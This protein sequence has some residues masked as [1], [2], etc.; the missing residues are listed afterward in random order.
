MS[1][2]CAPQL[3]WT[4]AQEVVLLG[5]PHRHTKAAASAS[6]KH[7]KQGCH[8]AYMFDTKQIRLAGKLGA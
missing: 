4:A 6:G 5:E 1:N 2:F 8:A 7:V 3:R